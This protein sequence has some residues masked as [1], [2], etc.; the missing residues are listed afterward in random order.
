MR[1][2]CKGTFQIQSLAYLLNEILPCEDSLFKKGKRLHVTKQHLVEPTYAQDKSYNVVVRDAVPQVTL[3]LSRLPNTLLSG[4]IVHTTIALQAANSQ[5]IDKIFVI[6]DSPN[7]ISF[8]TSEKKARHLGEKLL[9]S[10][11][12]SDSASF[13]ADMDA[14]QALEIFLTFRGD[15]VGLNIVNFVFGVCSRVRCL[16]FSA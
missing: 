12:L 3:D 10:S 11:E 1:F 16:S 9:L 14:N 2:H 7:F 15:A 6:C 5:R 13:T 8:E 4:Q